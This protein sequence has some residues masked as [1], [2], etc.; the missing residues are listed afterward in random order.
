MA[1]R[2]IKWFTFSVGLMIL[3]IILSLIFHETFKIDV[4]FNCYS[5]EL[6]FI[7]V[8]LSATSIGDTYSLIQKGVKGIHLTII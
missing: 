7:A 8:T 4:N 5:S 1:E 3:P 2:L 6:L